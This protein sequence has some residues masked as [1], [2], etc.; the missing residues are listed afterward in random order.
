MFPLLISTPSQQANPLIIDIGISDDFV[1]T[2]LAKACWDLIELLR[3][4]PCEAHTCVG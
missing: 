3:T 2:V 4:V 1:T